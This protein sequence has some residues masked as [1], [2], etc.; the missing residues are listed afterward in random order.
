MVGQLQKHRAAH[1]QHRCGGEHDLGV[2]RHS[3]ELPAAAPH[4]QNDHEADA[5]HNDERI[6]DEVQQQIVLIGDQALPAA[7]CVK[8]RIVEGGDRVENAQP[9]RLQRHVIAGKRGKAE[10]RTGDL[11]DQGHQQDGPHKAHHALQAL[12]VQCLPH[13]GTAL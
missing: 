3:A 6:G 13:E 9:H 1:Q 12:D 8:A 11:A 4:V 7:Q 10:H 5:A 2:E